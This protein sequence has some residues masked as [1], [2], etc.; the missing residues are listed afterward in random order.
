RDS[1]RRLAATGHAG[2]AADAERR[3]SEGSMDQPGHIASTDRDCLLDQVVTAYLKALEAGET[4]DRGEWLARYPEL[5][6]DLEV[7]FTDQDRFASLAVPLQ[8]IVRAMPTETPED[9]P[10]EAKREA[11]AGSSF[12]DYDLLEEI[13]DGGMGV[14][15]KARRKGPDRL[16]ALK[17]VGTGRG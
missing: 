2:V 11:L 7:F 16:V 12:G 9:T 10:G 17:V 13:G 1:G 3:V 15:Y 4:P 14:V 6:A 5:A 8:A